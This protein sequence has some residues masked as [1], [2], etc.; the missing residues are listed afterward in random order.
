[1]VV[2]IVDRT[3]KTAAPRTSP[4]T[5]GPLQNLRHTPSL[6]CQYPSAHWHLQG[7]AGGK[8]AVCETC[9]R[10]N[11]PAPDLDIVKESQH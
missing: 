9:T 11:T 3:L 7:R 10:C 6:V 4:A 5:R 2:A 8:R 1:M